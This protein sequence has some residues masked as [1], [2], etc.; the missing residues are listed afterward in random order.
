MDRQVFRDLLFRKLDRRPASALRL[1]EIERFGA[2][3]YPPSTYDMRKGVR[4]VS[5]IQSLDPVRG[6]RRAGRGHEIR[7]SGWCEV[8]W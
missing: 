5:C 8:S 2:A 6:R 3:D 4:V 7:L 1:P